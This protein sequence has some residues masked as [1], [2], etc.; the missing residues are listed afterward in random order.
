VISTLPS[1]VNRPA[2]LSLGYPFEP[3]AEAIWS[4]ERQAHNHMD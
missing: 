4:V 2:D 3:N 1:S